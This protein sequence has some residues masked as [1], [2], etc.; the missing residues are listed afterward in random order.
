MARSNA[1]RLGLA[2]VAFA[3]GDWCA[4][5]GARRFDVVVSN[6]PYIEAADPHLA[7]G[8]LRFEP[9]AA[10]ASGADGLDAIRTISAQAP[11]HLNPHGWLL[12]EHGWDQG[13]RA[14]ALLSAAG[15]VDVRSVC[16][17]EARERVTL[18]RI[19]R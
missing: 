3:L 6:P 19:A 10:L 2:R 12:F 8:D 1:R 16:D 4:A 5:L 7:Q 14:R 17:L 9:A 13:A 15:F 11:A 18:G